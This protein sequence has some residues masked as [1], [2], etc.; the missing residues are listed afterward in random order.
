MTLDLFTT[1]QLEPAR[2]TAPAQC[3]LT[4]TIQSVSTPPTIEQRFAA[5]SAA[6]AHV[7]A[8]LLRLARAQL[9]LGATFIS[10]KAI[11]EQCRVSLSAAHEGGYRLNNDFTSRSARWLIEHEP[12]LATVIRTRTI[13]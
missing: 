1:A 7:L 10:T 2:P 5:W 13:K 3:P 11:W 6:N 8:E 9:A 4:E 12:R